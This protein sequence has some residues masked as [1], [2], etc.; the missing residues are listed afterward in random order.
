M[1]VSFPKIRLSGCSTENCT[2]WYV[3]GSDWTFVGQVFLTRFCLYTTC[4]HITLHSYSPVKVKSCSCKLF[5]VFSRCCGR[6]RSLI[7]PNCPKLKRPE[8]PQEQDAIVWIWMW[9]Q[10][11][12]ACGLAFTYQTKTLHCHTCNNFLGHSLG[13]GCLA[14]WIFKIPAGSYMTKKTFFLELAGF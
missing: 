8:F 5:V 11:R 14:R 12:Y 9:R 3:S 13:F 7:S 10:R 1:E 2:C 6:A 4:T